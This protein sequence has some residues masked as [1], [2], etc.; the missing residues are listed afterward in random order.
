MIYAVIKNGDITQYV[1][2]FKPEGEIVVVPNDVFSSI[3][4]YEF[5]NGEFI[6]K[7][8]QEQLPIQTTEQ[9]IAIVEKEN[10]K[11]KAE[12]EVTQAVVDNLLFGGAL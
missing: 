12:L 8:H 6:K 7:P 10:T 1:T 4:E 5:T 3:E 11:L 2:G 9:R